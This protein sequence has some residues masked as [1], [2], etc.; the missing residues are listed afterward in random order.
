MSVNTETTAP[1]NA[2]KIAVDQS[3]APPWTGVKFTCNACSA[4]FQLEAAD[5]CALH[6]TLIDYFLYEA[7]GCWNCGR[8]NLIRIAKS[9][10]ETK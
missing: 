10:E 1:A 4:E 7:P 8:V 2:V 9:K 3:P 5:G 6:A